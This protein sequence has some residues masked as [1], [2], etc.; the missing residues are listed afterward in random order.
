MTKGGKFG[1]IVNDKNDVI[2]Y[3]VECL[4][5]ASIEVGDLGSPDVSSI[6]IWRVSRLAFYFRMQVLYLVS[7]ILANLRSLAKL[8]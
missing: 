2:S 4:M 1:F 3:T 6:Q 7:F 8:A 5:L